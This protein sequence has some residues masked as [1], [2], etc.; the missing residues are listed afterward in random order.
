MQLKRLYAS[1]DGGRT[2]ALRSKDVPS[3]GYAYWLAFRSPDAGMLAAIRF[4]LIATSDGGRHWR[5][6]LGSGDWTPEAIA[7][8]SRRRVYVVLRN[9]GLARS[10]DGGRHWQQLYPARPGP[11]AGPVSFSSIRNGIGARSEGLDPDGGVIVATSDGGRT[12]RLR[13]RIPGF[14]V[15]Q[16]ERVSATSVWAVASRP[17]PHGGYAP[18]R[19]LRSGDDG[20]HWRQVIAVPA[21]GFGTLS[22]VDARVA[23]VYGEQGTLRTVDGGASWRRRSE[24]P[25]YAAAFLDRDRGYGMKGDDRLLATSDGGKAWQPVALPGR[26]RALGVSGDPPNRV[27]VIG[28]ACFGGRCRGRIL[29]SQD[30]G[31]RWTQINYNAAVPP[32]PAGWLDGR[33]AIVPVGVPGHYRTLDGGRSWHFVVAR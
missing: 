19:V 26:F 18:A 12:W 21:L 7:W 4:G 27:W 28:N 22:R 10:D 1:Q 16:L 3:G 6:S 29:R 2:W 32:F 31:A 8:P 11:P 13:S 14:H 15:R 5:L 25:I 24:E 20:R 33:F 30:G 23:F 9:L 17:L